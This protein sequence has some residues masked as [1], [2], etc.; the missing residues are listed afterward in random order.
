MLGK[1]RKQLDI[2]EREHLRYAHEAQKNIL[3]GTLGTGDKSEDIR[4]TKILFYAVSITILFIIFVVGQELLENI[5]PMP[6]IVS[7]VL[8]S[9]LFIPIRYILD[10]HIMKRYKMDREEPNARSQ[11][12]SVYEGILRDAWQDRIITDMESDMLRFIRKE[13]GISEE[14]HGDICISIGIEY[15][16]NGD[17]VMKR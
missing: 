17:Y 2:T 13:L 3:P 4:K 12:L 7:A 8:L 11:A 14:E 15:D 5:L 6:T 9:F 16:D 1:L 10:K